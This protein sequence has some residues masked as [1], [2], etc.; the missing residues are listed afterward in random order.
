MAVRTG[1]TGL[2]HSAVDQSVP[3]IDF[4]YRSNEFFFGVTVLLLK[5]IPKA[6]TGEFKLI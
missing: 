4:R 1:P 5:Q 6:S 2:P 3:C